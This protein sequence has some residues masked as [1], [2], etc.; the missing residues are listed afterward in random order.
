MVPPCFATLLFCIRKTWSES[1]RCGVSCELAGKARIFFNLGKY[2]DALKTFREVLQ[3]Y[4][5]CPASVRVGVGLCFLRQKN[6]DKALEAFERAR[7]IDPTDEGALIGCAMILMNKDK[8]ET[9]DVQ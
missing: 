2:E 6:Y 8:E 1:R 9:S 3:V 4:P 7:E 5:S